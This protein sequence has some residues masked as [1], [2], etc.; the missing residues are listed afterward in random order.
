MRP[1]LQKSLVVGRTEVS[2]AEAMRSFEPGVVYALQAPAAIGSQNSNSNSDPGTG[3]VQSAVE[4]LCVPS[5]TFSGHA[6]GT[7]L[8]EDSLAL[9]PNP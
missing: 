3:A 6:G 4:I 8:P 7:L 1:G 5:G 9:T 2:Q